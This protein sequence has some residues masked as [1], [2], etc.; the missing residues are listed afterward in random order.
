MP[1]LTFK[2]ICI[3]NMSPA[4]VEIQQLEQCVEHVHI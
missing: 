1:D 3:F 4:S 2:S